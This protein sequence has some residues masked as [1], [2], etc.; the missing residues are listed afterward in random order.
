M[1][2][3]C[4]ATGD[5]IIG[6]KTVEQMNKERAEMLERLEK[7]T[8][9]TIQDE[10][11]ADREYKKKQS[12]KEVARSKSKEKTREERYAEV[13]EKRREASRRAIKMNL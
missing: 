9:K 13:E 4:T 12:I 7:W 2:R 10:T 5:T 1:G 11:D 8:P 3:H 6:K